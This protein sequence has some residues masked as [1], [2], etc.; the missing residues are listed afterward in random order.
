LIYVVPKSL[1]IPEMHS[2]R[3]EYRKLYTSWFNSSP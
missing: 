1:S 2:V 3:D